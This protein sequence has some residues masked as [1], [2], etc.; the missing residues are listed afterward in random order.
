MNIFGFDAPAELIMNEVEMHKKA[1]SK[2][3][4]GQ[5]AYN[6]CCKTNMFNVNFNYEQILAYCILDK[7]EKHEMEKT[8]YVF[9]TKALY[10]GMKGVKEVL[11]IPYDEIVEISHLHQGKDALGYFVYMRDGSCKILLRYDN[12][13]SNNVIKEENEYA[14]QCF[15]NYQKAKVLGHFGNILMDIKRWFEQYERPEMYNYENG[16]PNVDM[17]LRKFGRAFEGEMKFGQLDQEGMQIVQMAA[18]SNG[19]GNIIGHYGKSVFTDIC[20]VTMLA[21][22]AVVVYY[23]QITD[24]YV[25]TVEDEKKHPMVRLVFYMADGSRVMMG[26]D[27][28][29]IY[30]LYDF[31]IE[32]LRRMYIGSTNVFEYHRIVRMK[33][34]VINFATEFGYWE[35]PVT[36][37][38]VGNMV[39]GSLRIAG[40]IVG[41]GFALFGYSG[42]SLFSRVIG[43]SHAN[44]LEGLMGLNN[45]TTVDYICIDSNSQAANVINTTYDD[46]AMLLAVK[47]M[48]LY[49]RYAIRYAMQNS[50]SY[51]SFYNFVDFLKPYFAHEDDSIIDA[52]VMAAEAM[53]DENYFYQRSSAS[54]LNKMINR[55][56]PGATQVT[57]AQALEI[58]INYLMERKVKGYIS[59][60]AA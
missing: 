10:Y 39:S 5:D 35:S 45:P 14:K 7:N 29:D 24:L 4:Y 31:F 51:N 42:L 9:T 37:K 54:L 52:D 27:I 48:E 36:A 46:K 44:A 18:C 40:S 41:A 21:N 20:M 1:F 38:D 22:E 12:Q 57:Q 56:Q 58:K 55:C 6:K 30:A 11:V 2:V 15:K 32:V 23:N 49:T 13:F 28:V 3:Y 60:Y 8:Y 59:V 26:E 43:S 25:E 33:K 16:Y 34:D 53:F 19:L 17:L 50:M 47:S